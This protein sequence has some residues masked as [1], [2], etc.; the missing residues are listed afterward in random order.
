MAF[1]NDALLQLIEE[2][3]SD[4]DSS[5]K[6]EQ[7]DQM[8]FDYEEESEDPAPSTNNSSLES[9]KKIL[10]AVCKDPSISLELMNEDEI[11]VQPDAIGFFDNNFIKINESAFLGLSNKIKTLSFLFI[12]AKEKHKDEKMAYQTA[13]EQFKDQFGLSVEEANK[14]INLNFPEK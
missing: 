12:L 8:E 1:D 11:S 6:E 10:F 7:V 2:R 13:F 14:E 3:K 5:D 9:F 4:F